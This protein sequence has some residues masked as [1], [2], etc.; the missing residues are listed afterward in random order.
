MPRSKLLLSL[1]F[2]TDKH[3]A[4][5]WLYGYLHEARHNDG[6][7]GDT[8]GQGVFIVCE[9]LSYVPLYSECLD[10]RDTSVSGPFSFATTTL[11]ERIF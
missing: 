10:Q 8:K 3:C 9:V 7:F 5:N 4:R 11:T 1:L 6:H 2:R